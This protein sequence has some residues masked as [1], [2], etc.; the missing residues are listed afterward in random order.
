MLK[1]FILDTFAGK[2]EV[3][4]LFFAFLIFIVFFLHVRMINVSKHVNANVNKNVNKMSM[5]M[6]I[7]M[8]T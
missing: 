5:K 4:P 2:H 3:K 7:R 8:S 6:S 1:T